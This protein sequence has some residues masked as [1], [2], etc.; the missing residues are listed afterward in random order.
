MRLLRGLTEPLERKEVFF[1]MLSIEKRNRLEAIAKQLRMDTITAL[2]HAG[3][4][5]PG[6]ALSMTEIMAVLY[7]EEMNIRPD[8]PD[9]ADRD[10]FVLSKGHAC[11]SYYA[12]LARRGYFDVE[13]LKTLRQPGSI[14]QGHPAMGKTPGVD[15]STGSLGQGLSAAAGMAMY[16]K[17]KHKDFYVYCVMGDGECGEGQIWEA[18]MSAGHFKLNNLIAF[19]DANHLQIDGRVD[20]V[21][22]IYPMLEKFKAFG[23]NVMEADGHDVGQL[24]DAVE[25]AK[26]SDDKPT[27]ILCHTVKGKGVSLME[28]RVEWH[29]SQVTEEVY[30]RAMAELEG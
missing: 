2:Y 17:K 21:M 12:A 4:G 1:I 10:R 6:G 16:A 14:L 22:N 24:A 18:A 3:S 25:R 5:H 23:W 26:L 28:N 9:W 11:P 19:L 8:Q 29:G 30:H 20:D 13:E 15:M 27:F 7:F